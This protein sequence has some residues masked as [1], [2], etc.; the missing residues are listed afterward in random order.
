MGKAIE[1]EDFH[2]WRFGSSIKG[3][4][5]EF[6]HTFPVEELSKVGLTMPVSI[7]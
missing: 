6:L 1:V 2:T 3:L 7:G 4:M 5:I